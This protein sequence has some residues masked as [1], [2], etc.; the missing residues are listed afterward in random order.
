[1][2]GNDGER[3]L[4]N[5]FG[6]NFAK[7]M[8]VFVAMSVVFDCNYFFYIIFVDL[9]LIFIA[10][11]IVINCELNVLSEFDFHGGKSVEFLIKQPGL[12]IQKDHGGGCKNRSNCVP[13]STRLCCFNSVE[14]AIQANKKR[15]GGDGENND[16]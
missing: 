2:L 16:Y 10:P 4:M 14:V 1:M 11:I 12:P 3:G 13:K 8:N 6:N 5:T 9:D 7:K 15:K